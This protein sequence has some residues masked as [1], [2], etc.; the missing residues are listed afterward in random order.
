[1]GYSANTISL[2][3]LIMA[4]GLV[5]DDAIVVVENVHRVMSDEGLTPKRATIRAMKQVTGPVI[6]TT[7]VL[8]AVFVPV[9][10]MPGITGQLYRQFAVTMCTSVLISSLCALSLSPAL[11][12]TFLRPPTPHNRGPFGLFN[13]LV[14]TARQGYVRGAD[15]L[16]RHL[17]LAIIILGLIFGGSGYLFSKSPTSFLPQE[18][19]GYFF[20]NIQLPESAT[21]SRTTEVM[22]KITADIKEID[23]VKD[24]IGVAGFSLLAGDA[25]NVGLGVAILEPW[26]DRKLPHQ[27]LESI[28]GQSQGKLAAITDASAFAF[29]PPPIMGLGNS[30]GFDFRLQAKAG[31]SPQELFGTALSLMMAANQ[32]PA[33]A[34]VFTTF[35]ANTPQ[36]FVDIDRTKTQAMGVPV[37]RIFAT[38]QAQ[39]G[40]A[41]VNDFNLNGRT[42]QVKVQAKE[43]ERNTTDDIEKLYVRSDTGAMVPLKSLVHI[44]TILGP[45]LVSRYNQFASANF[46]GQGAPGVSSSEAMAAMERLAKKILPAGF[47]YDWSAMSFQEKKAGGQVL[48]LF[49]LALIFAYLFLVGQYESWNIPLAVIGSIPVA[50]LGALLGL[51]LMKM[52]LS[53]YAQIGL[54]LLV[55]LAAKNAILIVEFAKERHNDGLSTP[56]AAIAGAKIR[57]RPVMMTAFTFILGVI[58]MVLATGAGAGSRRAIGVTVF[59]GMLISTLLGIFIIPALYAIFQYASD[60]GGAWR[61]RQRNFAEINDSQGDKNA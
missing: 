25:D 2:F 34:R 18:D 42:Y 56:K 28:V 6:A 29:A 44:K 60:R 5:V 27:H 22:H 59:S 15:Y 54:V 32:D 13:R 24:V 48:G 58:P 52:P 11:C 21:L 4:I 55:G 49:G 43:S 53:I 3:A 17:L 45:Q 30:G 7:L 41:Y 50:S 31:Q 8:L 46:N 39:L 51:Y 38:L 23:G 12:A 33:L 40:S 14:V 20:M 35:T 16:I 9:G 61:D 37:S 26:A 47:G 10:F 36:L 57:F 19:Q 1:L